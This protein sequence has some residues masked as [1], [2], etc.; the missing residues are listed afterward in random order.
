[1]SEGELGDRLSQKD[2]ACCWTA[3]YYTLFRAETTTLVLKNSEGRTATTIEEKE[4]LVRETLFPPALVA[5]IERVISSER[6][7]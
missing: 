3:L 7:Y 5:G 2:S 1:L 6:A 4:A